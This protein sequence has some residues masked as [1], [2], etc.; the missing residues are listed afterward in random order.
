V[1]EETIAV[2]LDERP[3]YVEFSG[4]RDSS[5]VLAA[6]AEAC[7]R[8]GHAAPVPVTL[9]FP[10]PTGDEQY[11]EQVVEH[12][13]LTEWIVVRLDDPDLLGEPARAFVAAHGLVWP[14]TFSVRA[15]A[16]A[17]LPPGLFLSGEGGDEVLGPRRASVAALPL[18]H[19]RRRQRPPASSLRTACV[20]VAPRVLRSRLAA[21]SLLAGGYG[22][23]LEPS[24]RSR[25]ARRI[26]DLGAAEPWRPARWAGY[27]LAR[28]DVA[29]GHAQVERLMAEAGHRWV[30][31]L[32]SLR[33]VAAVGAARWHQHRGRTDFLRTHFA[34]RLPASVIERRD[35]ARFN[36]VYFGPRTR[37]FARR[38]DG[39]G[40]PPGVDAAWL[41]HH[42]ATSPLVHSGTALLLHAA[43]LSTR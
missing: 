27:Y 7:R 8:S 14:A 36:S 38:W 32:T 20:A 22:A 4:G 18:R 39:T 30:A 33:F 29:L 23:W 37:E 28:P 17:K 19:L 21:R 34:D 24:L 12:L 35:K 25:Y 6:A 11:Q 40:L 2:L 10:E 13:A 43:W 41:K 16:L 5:A 1:L 31:P 26:A 42:W 9:A 15:D 3:C